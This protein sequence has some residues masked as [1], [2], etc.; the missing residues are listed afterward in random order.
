MKVNIKNCAR[1]HGNHEDVEFVRFNTPVYEGESLVW[2]H[3]AMCP[4]NEE[5]ILLIVE[6]K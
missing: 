6:A 1:C 3:W 4:T 2:T 5:P